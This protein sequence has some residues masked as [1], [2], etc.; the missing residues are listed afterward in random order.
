MVEDR[1]DVGGG[2]QTRDV[3]TDESG[4]DVVMVDG[5]KKADGVESETTGEDLGPGTLWVL[6]GW[7]PLCS[8]ESSLLN[9]N[10]TIGRKALIS[11][12]HCDYR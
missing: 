11:G 6:L 5:G 10:P 3:D 4:G 2:S 7:K 8:R 1:G 9:S 12:L